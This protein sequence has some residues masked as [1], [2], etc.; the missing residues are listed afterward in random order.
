MVGLSVAVSVVLAL[1]NRRTPYNASLEVIGKDPALRRSA[2]S[3]LEF[4]AVGRAGWPTGAAAVEPCSARMQASVI[5]VRNV[6]AA[7]E[8]ASADEVEGDG[9]EGKRKSRENGDRGAKVI[10]G[11]Y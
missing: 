1:S 6:K 3:A 7:T 5:V 10:A 9:D 2:V 11:W 4:E 8:A